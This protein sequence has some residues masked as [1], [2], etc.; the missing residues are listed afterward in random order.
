V[1]GL[2]IEKDWNEQQLNFAKRK[3]QLAKT[4]NNL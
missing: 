3:R 4:A 2:K 1:D